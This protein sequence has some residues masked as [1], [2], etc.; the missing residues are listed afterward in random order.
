LDEEAPWGLASWTRGIWDEMA[1][2]NCAISNSPIGD[3]P[4]VFRNE[5]EGDMPGN[6]WDRAVDAVSVIS[7]GLGRR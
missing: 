1:E 4:F 5:P 6:I 7:V 3:T 2:T